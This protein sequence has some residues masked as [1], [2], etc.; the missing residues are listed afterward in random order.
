MF[1][2]SPPATA[3]AGVAVSR[4]HAAAD[5]ISTDD[6]VA[7]EEP[8]EI[9][10]GGRSVAVV[11][12][13]PG[14]DRELAAGFLLSEGVIRRRDDLLDL[15]ACRDQ[16]S[17]Q[18]GN[19]ID[20][21]V[22]PHVSVDFDQLTRHVFSASSCGVCGKATIDAVFRAGVPQVPSETHFDPQVLA[23]LPAALAAAQPGFGATGGVHASALVTPDGRLEIVREDVGRHNALDKV[24]GWALHHDSLP[25]DRH[26]L[27]VSGRISFE[28]VQKALVAGIPLIAGIGA[29]S[30]L[31]VDCARQA[32]Q[33]LIG[34]LRPDRMNVYT[35]AARVRATG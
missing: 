32:N 16:D 11:M 3:T 21:V 14:H 1:P 13:T 26:A 12:R 23:A 7:V 8:L 31:A 28:L 34:F 22:A 4:W 30:S 20:A 6:L 25:L 10:V 24:L 9:R 19:V 33:T 17:G 5:S 18:S 35:H 27:L 15:L 29:P 2:P